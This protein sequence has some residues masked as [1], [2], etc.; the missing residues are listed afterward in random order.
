MGYLGPYILKLSLNTLVKGGATPLSLAAM[1]F[2]FGFS[3]VARTYFDGRRIKVNGQIT[4]LAFLDISAKVY[5]SLLN[6]DL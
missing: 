4:R 6:L 2:T 1:F 5:E 3:Q